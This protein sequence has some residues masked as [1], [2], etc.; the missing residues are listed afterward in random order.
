MA[1]KTK[2]SKRDAISGFLATHCIDYL[3]RAGYKVRTFGPLAH[4]RTQHCS[5]HAQ[6]IWRIFQSYFGVRSALRH[7]TT[8]MTHRYPGDPNLGRVKRLPLY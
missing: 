8:R 3:P 1:A 7:N 5:R 2:P 6:G 4:A